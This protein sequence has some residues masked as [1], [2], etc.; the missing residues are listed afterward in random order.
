MKQA[1]L[2]FK[3]K[4]LRCLLQVLSFT[5]IALTT[6]SFATPAK[7]ATGSGQW[8][9]V[10]KRTIALTGNIDSGNLF[11]FKLVFDEDVRTVVLNSGGGYTYEA[12]QIGM[13]LKDAE[14]NVV[15]NGL[16][17]SSC[18]NYLFTAGRQKTIVDGIV[19]FHGNTRTLSV[20]EGVEENSEV[21][22]EGMN[23]AAQDSYETEL[24]QTIAWENIFFKE[25]GI[26]QTLFDRTQRDDK[27]MDDGETYAFL[28]P[29]HTTFLRYGIRN[30]KGEQSLAVKRDVEAELSMPLVID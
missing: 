6:L 10:D 27:G 1:L 13:I 8:T 2:P 25:L 9:R 30:V 15:V 21:L 18:A 16:C 24:E 4:E 11:R 3:S 14:V 28:L 22:P 7:L 23:E 5:L 17:L 29:T 19:G 20:Q 26:N 12:I